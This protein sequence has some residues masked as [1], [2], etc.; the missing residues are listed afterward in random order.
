MRYLDYGVQKKRQMMLFNFFYHFLLSDA[1]NAIRG[2]AHEILPSTE[3]FPEIPQSL[4]NL[5]LHG[6]TQRI[7][8]RKA[9]AVRGIKSI[10]CSL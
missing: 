3:R 8:H 6:Q 1:L 4:V 2:V 7:V 10:I 5:F 9:D